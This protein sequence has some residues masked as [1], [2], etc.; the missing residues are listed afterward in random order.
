MRGN[1]FILR[2]MQEKCRAQ[3]ESKPAS[4]HRKTHQPHRLR[5]L[6]DIFRSYM[7]ILAA[8]VLHMSLLFSPSLFFASDAAQLRSILRV[9]PRKFGEKSHSSK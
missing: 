8:H 4:L 2:R 6:T 1:E 3:Q 7:L 9:P 5:S